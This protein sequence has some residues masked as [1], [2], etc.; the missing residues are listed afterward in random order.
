M[1]D[2]CGKVLYSKYT[3]EYHLTGHNNGNRQYTCEI[4]GKT[5]TSFGSLQ[6]HLLLHSVKYTSCSV[7]GEFFNNKN[8]LIQHVQF[9]HQNDDQFKCDKCG[10]GFDGQT[11]LAV[12]KLVKHNRLRGLGKSKFGSEV[13]SGV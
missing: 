4:C 1:C 2:V 12:H 8:K 13:F 3:L 10:K 7:C 9:A 11:N 6:G 5:M